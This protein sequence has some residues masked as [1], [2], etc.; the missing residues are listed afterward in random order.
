LFFGVAAL[1]VSPHLENEISLDSR[2]DNFILSIL[3]FQVWFQNRRAKWRK[4]EKTIG[5]ES[6]T[7]SASHLLDRL[8]SKFRFVNLFYEF[9]SRNLYSF[10]YF[11]CFSFLNNQV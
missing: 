2:E 3:F 4:K 9:E 7:F 1:F 11:I 6:P 8:S 5:G 10:F